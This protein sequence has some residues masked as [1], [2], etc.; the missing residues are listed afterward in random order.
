MQQVLLTL[1]VVLPVIFWATYH[2]HQDRDLPEP[3]SRL[4]LA[5]GLGL[6]SVGL[7]KV[8]YAGLVPLGL[9]YDAV[10]LAENNPAHLLVYAM[11]AIGPI[12]EFAKLVPFVAVIIHLKDFDEPVDGIIYA[13]FIGLGYAAAENVLYL[14]YLTPLAAAARGFASPVVHMMFASIWAHWVTTA[15]LARRP[16]L[17]PAVLGFLLAAALHGFY[18]FLVLQSPVAAL[19]I[20][21]TLIVTL[22]IWRLFVLRRLRRTAARQSDGPQPRL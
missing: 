14:D 5:F 22:W 17:K 11:F 10:A 21:A 9:H 18:D 2:Y 12:E 8:L 6:L 7:A 20:A 13:S 3:A 19:P 4:L 15:W 1:P 16:I